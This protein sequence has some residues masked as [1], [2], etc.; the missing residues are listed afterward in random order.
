MK[1]IFDKT[2]LHRTLGIS[3]CFT[4]LSC[5]CMT[6][7]YAQGEYEE[8]VAVVKK[9]AKVKKEKT[10]RMKTVTG[11]VTDDATG[12]PLSLIHI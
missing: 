3:L 5:L 2:F 4:A 1:K 10:Y 6:N 9:P 8:E 11:L 12:E 7:V